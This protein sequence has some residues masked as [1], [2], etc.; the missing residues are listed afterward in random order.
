MADNMKKIISLYRISLL[1]Q[2]S[3]KTNFILEMSVWLIYSILPLLAVNLFLGELRTNNDSLLNVTN[4]M[5]GCIFISYNL[6]RMFGRG[7]DNYQQLLFSG[8]LD[9]YFSRPLPIISQ[10]LGS[11]LF[12]RRLSGILAGLAALIRSFVSFGGISILVT[13]SV[14]T[15]LFIMYLGLLLISAS[16]LALTT[17]GNMATNFL[18]DSSSNFGFYPTEMLAK[19]AKEIFTFIIPIYFCA[20]API[21]KAISREYSVLEIFSSITAAIAVLCIGIF[22]FNYSLSKYKSANG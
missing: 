13:I 3:Y 4:L 21:K 11:S 15:S 12:I 9:V 5:Y 6:A 22:V 7:F 1:S 10:I 16:F 2:L 17:K 19:P 14:I 20:F 18:V 8:E